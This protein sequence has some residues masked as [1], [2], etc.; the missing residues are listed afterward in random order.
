MNATWKLLEAAILDSD[1][2]EHFLEADRA[3]EAP[4][5]RI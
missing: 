2:G 5:I 3:S 4:H 1:E